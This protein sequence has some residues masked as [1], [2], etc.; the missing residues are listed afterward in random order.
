MPFFTTP[1]GIEY[2]EM[3]GFPKHS[4]QRD[5]SSLSTQW[6]I[7]G[8]DLKAF[9]DEC[10]PEPTAGGSTVYSW[11]LQYPKK[12]WLYCQSLSLEPLGGE[13]AIPTFDDVERTN[14]YEFWVANLEFGTLSWEEKSDPN[15]NDVTL[16]T[17]D[18][19]FGG[20]YVNLQQ[21]KLYWK[22][23][24]GGNEIVEGDVDTGKLI[25]TVEYN[26]TLHNYLYL[27]IQTITKNLGKVNSTANQLI[28]HEAPETLLFIGASANRTITWQGTGLWQMS[29]RFSEKAIK[30]TQSGTASTYGWNHFWRPEQSI[31]EKVVDA[32]NNLIFPTTDL[33]K[34]FWAKV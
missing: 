2:E 20:E 24:N 6:K 33:S 19:S 12:P 15:T 5:R 16:V 17:I 27:P 22:T 29:L 13:D 9:M 23:A 8:G 31:Y 18:V 11:P 26:I 10:F 25:P 3:N 30:H 14:A 32:N 4:V 34:L 21:F 7:S 1:S 28:G